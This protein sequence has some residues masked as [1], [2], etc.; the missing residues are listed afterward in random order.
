MLSTLRC[1]LSSSSTLFPCPYLPT[2]ASA[3]PSQTAAPTASLKADIANIKKHAV[4][5]RAIC[6]TQADKI[7]L[8]FKKANIAEIQVNGGD[9]AKKVDFIMGLLEQQIPLDTVFKKDTLIDTCAVNKVGPQR[10]LLCW[11][12]TWNI[13]N[14]F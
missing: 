9:A 10:W 12:G 7:R 13:I 2:F 14:L 1:C 6:H 3:P 4:V 8:G 11:H 5:V